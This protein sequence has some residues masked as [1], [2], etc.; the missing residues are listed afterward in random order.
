MPPENGRK[1]F[2][3]SYPEHTG[4]FGDFFE[5]VETGDHQFPFKC[6]TP[7]ELGSF[8]GQIL[9]WFSDYKLLSG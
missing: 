7:N 5:I 3:I 6:K 1:I 4:L 8:Y 2:R 9:Q